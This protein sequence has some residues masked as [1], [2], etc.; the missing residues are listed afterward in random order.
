[1]V[2]VAAEVRGTLVA[3]LVLVVLVVVELPTL[4]VERTEQLILAAAAVQA[5][6][7]LLEMVVQ[8]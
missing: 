8:A 1:V 6:L 2:V 3:H 7:T 4:L 5:M